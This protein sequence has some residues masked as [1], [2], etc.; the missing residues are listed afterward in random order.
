MTAEYTLEQLDSLKSKEAEAND[1]FKDIGWLMESKRLM[2]RRGSI[3][4]TRTCPNCGKKVHLVLAGH[5]QHL[6]ASCETPNCIWM[7]E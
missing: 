1:I 3:R 6:H 2:K 5:K 4:A 7:M